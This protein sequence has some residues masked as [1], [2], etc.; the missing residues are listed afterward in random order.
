MFLKTSVPKSIC[1]R[2]HRTLT[3]PLSIKREFGP[4]CYRKVVEPTER[5]KKMSTKAKEIK[6]LPNVGEWFGWDKNELTN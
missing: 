5:V 4:V 2:C 1:N 6:E 3:D